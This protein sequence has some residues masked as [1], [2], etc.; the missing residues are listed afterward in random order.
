MI[1][2]KGDNYTFGSDKIK[3]KRLWCDTPLLVVT[4]KVKPP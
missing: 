1:Q 3:K 4:A 2:K